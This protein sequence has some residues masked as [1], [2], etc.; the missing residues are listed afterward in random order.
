MIRMCGKYSEHAYHGIIEGNK[1][2]VLTCRLFVFC[3]RSTNCSVGS[4]SVSA[5]TL[6]LVCD[7]RSQLS[8]LVCFLM[9]STKSLVFFCL[10]WS[11][12]EV[13]RAGS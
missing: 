10:P 6:T 7:R 4:V 9:S 5:V 2:K 12:G 1:Q 3:W 8:L 11:L 13:E